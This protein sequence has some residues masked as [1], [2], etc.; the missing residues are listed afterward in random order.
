LLEEFI[1]LALDQ[2]LVPEVRAGHPILSEHVAARISRPYSQPCV[3][4]D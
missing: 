2:D 4:T 1:H 3:L